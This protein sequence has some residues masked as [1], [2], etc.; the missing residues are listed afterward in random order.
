MK[1]RNQPRTR[2]RRGIKT[3][4]DEEMKATEDKSEEGKKDKL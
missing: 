2:V 4:D 3:N 1:R